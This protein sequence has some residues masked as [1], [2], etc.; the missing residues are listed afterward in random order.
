MIEDI[1]G[2]KPNT[3]PAGTLNDMFQK[4]YLG[5]DMDTWLEKLEEH[6]APYDELLKAEPLMPMDIKSVLA[7]EGTPILIDEGWFQELKEKA[8][9]WD[10]LGVSIGKARTQKPQKWWL[11]F[12]GIPEHK[13]ILE[14]EE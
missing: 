7:K 14:S 8:D 2:E 1:L 9:K 4:V 6:Y 12:C 10:K 3:V 11:D 13:E 5:K